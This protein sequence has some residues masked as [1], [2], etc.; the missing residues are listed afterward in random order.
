MRV[1]TNR[2]G[3]RD[4]KKGD[5]QI[6]D[7]VEATIYFDVEVLL[8]GDGLPRTSVFL[9]FNEVVRLRRAVDLRMEVCCSIDP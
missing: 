9:A 8:D 4:A 7:L 3:V 6:G 5:L 2:G 1:A